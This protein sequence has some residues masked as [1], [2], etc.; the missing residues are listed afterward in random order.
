[1]VALDASTLA[2]RKALVDPHYSE[3]DS[4]KLK[5]LVKK[6]REEIEENKED[7]VFGELVRPGFAL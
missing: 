5:Y 4:A 7:F 6:E 3:I 1:M 2:E